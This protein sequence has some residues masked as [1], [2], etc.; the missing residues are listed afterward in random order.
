MRERSCTTHTQSLC[1]GSSRGGEASSLQVW[2]IRKDVRVL[3]EPRIAPGRID[4]NAQA[5]RVWASKLF[6]H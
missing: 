2:R 3:M 5:N 1:F 4:T 6:T